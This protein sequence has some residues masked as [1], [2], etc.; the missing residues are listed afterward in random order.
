MRLS[1]RSPYLD[2]PKQQQRDRRGDPDFIR[3]RRAGE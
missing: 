1:L 2:A 3:N